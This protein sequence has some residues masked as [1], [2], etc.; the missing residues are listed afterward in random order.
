MFFSKHLFIP[1][2]NIDV[3]IVVG[4]HLELPQIENP[5]AE[6]VDKYHNLYVQEVIQLFNRNVDKY[7]PGSELKI[8]GSH[9][10]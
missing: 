7:D 3:S 6:E 8:W 2:R 9:K 4:K 1:E 10:P 5:T